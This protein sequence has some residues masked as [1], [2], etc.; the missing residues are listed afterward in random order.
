MHANRVADGL[1]I[2]QVKL[3]QI[4]FN[5]FADL[6]GITCQIEGNID[7]QD[8]LRLTIGL[9]VNDQLGMANSE[10]ILGFELDVD[11]VVRCARAASGRGSRGASPLG[12]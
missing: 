2:F 5:G 9:V 10:I 1:P 4:E 7:R 3:R 11:R 12:C 8:F 6:F